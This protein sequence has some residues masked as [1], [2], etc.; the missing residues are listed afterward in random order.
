MAKQKVDYEKLEELQKNIKYIASDI[1]TSLDTII[2]K[3]DRIANDELWVGP[4]GDAF[5]AAISDFFFDTRLQSVI[6]TNFLYLDKFL[7]DVLVDCK[8]ADDLSAN[9]I[10]GSMK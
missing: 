6:E 2:Q 7:S 8:S 5:N 4:N 9:I 3:Y 1:G 10:E